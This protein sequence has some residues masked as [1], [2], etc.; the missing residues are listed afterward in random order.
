MHDNQIKVLDCTFRDGGYYT[1]WKFNK[2]IV[3]RYF[4]SLK[5]SK[6]DII[7]LGFRFLKKIVFTEILR[8]QTIN[9]YHL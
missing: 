9:S 4:N 2:T 6:I 8:T 3:S 7:E 5:E 1:D